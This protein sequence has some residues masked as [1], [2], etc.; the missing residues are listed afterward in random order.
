MALTNAERQKRWREK[1]PNVNRSCIRQWRRKQWEN[2][3]LQNNREQRPVTEEDS[4]NMG[5]TEADWANMFWH[6]KPGPV[7]T[8]VRR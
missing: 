4:A 5:V 1:H 3:A 8:A 7:A 6:P 2:A